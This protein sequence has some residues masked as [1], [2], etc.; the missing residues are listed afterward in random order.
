MCVVLTQLVCTQEV[1][2][3]FCS[4][5]SDLIWHRWLCGAAWTSH[6]SAFSASLFL[7]WKQITFNS[8][9]E[10]I[11]KIYLY[12]QVPVIINSLR[13]SDAI[14]RQR[15]GSTLA[16]AWRHQAITWTNVDWL[17]VRSCGIHQRALSWDDLKIPISKTRL[18]I[19]FSESH[20]DLL[21]ANEL[22]RWLILHNH[23]LTHSGLDMM[24]MITFTT[25]WKGPREAELI[26]LGP[27]R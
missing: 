15:S 11:S 1:P 27:L 16:Q 9:R 17:S 2:F 19:T 26:L 3:C 4:K 24:M 18:E 22:K 20:S 6:R 5:W 21:G 7:L 10:I 25:K 14:G 13:P 8:V 23:C 12:E